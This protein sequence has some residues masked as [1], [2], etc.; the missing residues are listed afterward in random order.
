V[1]TTN[2]LRSHRPRRPPRAAI[3]GSTPAMTAIGN[4]QFAARPAADKPDALAA[5]VAAAR[6]PDSF[7]VG[8]PQPT[9]G[10]GHRRLLRHALLRRATGARP[11]CGRS[12]ARNRGT[13][14]RNRRTNYRNMPSTGAWSACPLWTATSC[15]WR[16]SRMIPRRHPARHHHRRSPGTGPQVFERRIRPVRERG[17][18]RHPP[19]AP[20]PPIP[21]PRILEP[22]PSLQRLILEVGYTFP[23]EGRILHGPKEA[24]PLCF[25][26]NRVGLLHC[27][28]DSMGLRF[29]AE[30]AGPFRYGGTGSGCC[31]FSPRCWP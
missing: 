9:G 23:L 29:Q 27:A 28:A 7:S 6:P 8:R 4:G 25:A 31:Q 1:L 13:R 19:E 17:A 11:L 14:R 26:A 18:G 15:A 22:L 5:Q 2:T 30:S 12:G 3:K 10:R 21:S 24:Q 20:Q 16:S